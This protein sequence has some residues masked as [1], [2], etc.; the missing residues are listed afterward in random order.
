M[1]NKKS[2]KFQKS[3]KNAK[4]LITNNLKIKD[5]KINPLNIIEETK[6]KFSDYY[7][8]VKKEKEKEKIK[9]AKKREQDKK[10]SIRILL[11]R[12]LGLQRKRMI[13]KLSSPLWLDSLI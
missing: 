8:K 2:N 9:L 1:N 3:F 10:R 7:K 11:P 12:Y 5:I 6:N 13:T 4:S